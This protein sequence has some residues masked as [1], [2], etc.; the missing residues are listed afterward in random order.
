MDKKTTRFIN[1]P[2]KFIHLRHLTISCTILGDPKSAL[3]VLRVTQILESAP[4]LQHF[5]L[6]MHSSPLFLKTPEPDSIHQHMH[7][8][9]KTVQMTGMLGLPGQLE[10]AKYILLSAN[11]LEFM[12]LNLGRN[13]IRQQSKS[14]YTYFARLEKFAKK[15]LDPQGVYHSVLKIVGLTTLV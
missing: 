11:V 4:Q 10:L 7:N 5:V 12:I 6:H 9:L 15:Y 8:H 3:V 13:G 14:D 2:T 1:N